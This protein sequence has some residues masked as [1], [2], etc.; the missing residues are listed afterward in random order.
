MIE[1]APAE[2]CKIMNR[3]AAQMHCLFLEVDGKKGWR[4][5]TFDEAIENNN[6]VVI[7]DLIAALNSLLL[8]D[9]TRPSFGYWHQED[10]DDPDLG[11]DDDLYWIVPVRDK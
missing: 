3:S 4:F 2:Y 6:G 1:I 7:S 9:I 10:L 8:L 5:P 11:D